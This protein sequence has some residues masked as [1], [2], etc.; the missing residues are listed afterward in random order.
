MTATDQN[1]QVPNV[2]KELGLLQKMQKERQGSRACLFNLILYGEEGHRTENLR[3]VFEAIIDKYPCRLIYIQGSRSSA[4][5]YLRVSVDNTKGNK[6]GEFICDR[7]NIDVSK[8][9]FPKIPFLILSILVPDL[10]IYILWDQDPTIDNEILPQ[11][12]KYATRLIF[13]SECTANLP[14]FG[15]KLL[16]MLQNVKIDVMDMNWAV[17]AG[18][19]DALFR[20][21]DSPTRIQHLQFGRTIEIEYARNGNNAPNQNV[22]QAIYLQAWLASRLK[23]KFVSL[24]YAENGNTFV[25]TSR[26]REIT[27]KLI[28]KHTSD[29]VPGSI[30]SF[31]LVTPDNHIYQ[32]SKSIDSNKIAIHVSC[33]EKCDMPFVVLL[34][35]MKSSYSLMREIFYNTTS[36]H[37]RSMLEALAL[38]EKEVKHNTLGA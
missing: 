36:T 6:A 14:L 4:E 37:Y 5:E 30:L 9:N 17:M 20:T 13:S 12:Q 32:L 7:V 25:Y 19:R 33:M 34:P 38:N 2:Q 26:E 10:P 23:W 27:V 11:L 3:K 15:R 18:W 1:I 29:V 28:P 22:T 21:F 8:A 24:Q 35:D 31:R 16:A